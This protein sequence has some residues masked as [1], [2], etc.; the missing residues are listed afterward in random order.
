VVSAHVSE[1]DLSRTWFVFTGDHGEATGEDGRFGHGFDFSDP[2]TRVPFFILGPGIPSG[3]VNDISL[4]QDLL[5]TL[6]TLLG[7]K[8]PEGTLGRSVVEEAPG[9]TGAS[10]AQRWVPRRGEAR[11]ALF[12]AYSEAGTG[13]VFAQ[14]RVGERRLEIRLEARR[15][16]LEVVGFRDARG[17]PVVFEPDQRTVDAFVELFRRELERGVQA[18]PR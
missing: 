11:G 13:R 2:L 12:Q 10:G 18:L 17:K 1:L 8:W 16:H 14:L 4:H 3:V 9:G 15:P 6:A 7:A 5:P